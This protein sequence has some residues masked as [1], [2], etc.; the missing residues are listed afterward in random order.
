MIYNR[1]LMLGSV[2]AARMTHDNVGVADYMR[3]SIY[4]SRMEFRM[5]DEELFNTGFT[6]ISSKENSKLLLCVKLP[7]SA[8]VP[9]PITTVSQLPVES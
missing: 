7:K 1:I 3:I 6:T 5:T 4:R 9:I 8:Q 2:G